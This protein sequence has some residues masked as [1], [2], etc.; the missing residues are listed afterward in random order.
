[1]TERADAVDDD[2]LPLA[3]R[4]ALVTGGGR[5]IGAAIAVELARLGADLTLTGRSEAH[6]DITATEINDR[7]KVRVAICPMD[8]SVETAV[9]DTV[10]FAAEKL[11]PPTILINN[12]GVAPAGPFE[13]LDLEIWRHAFGVNVEGVFLCTHAVLNGMREAGWGRIVNIASTAGLTAYSHVAAYVASK[14]AVVGMTRALALELARTG[15]TV[16]AV[17]PGYT[18]TDMAHGAIDNLVAAG[19][20]EDEARKLLAKKNPQG[21]LVQPDEVA[22]AA[23]WLCLPGSAAVT[24]QA[25]AVAGG[26]V[27]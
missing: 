24:G 2:A 27:M 5:G 1:M 13:D 3:G 19:R 25:V 4:H 8:I 16:N 12:A 6:L 22:Q 7:Y 17:C 20:S 14:H 9:R 15:I 26:E 21:R 11:G 10:T 18:E 23:G